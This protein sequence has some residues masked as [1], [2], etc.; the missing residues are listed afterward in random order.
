MSTP[1]SGKPYIIA[2]VGAN[3]NGSF[4]TAMGLID[5]AALAKA[6][7]VK[8][9]IIF[10]EGLYLPEFYEN[11]SYR[12][13]PVIEQRRKLML[14]DSE[15]Q[16]LAEHAKEKNIDFSASVFDERGLDLLLECSPKY[17]KL[18]SCDL[19]NPALLR[20]AAEKAG[21]KEISIILSTGFSTYEEIERSVNTIS[22]SGFKD[23]ILLHCVSVYPVRLAQ[24]NLGFIDQ[25]KK[26]GFPV[27]LSDHT[28]SN[29]AAAVALAKGARYFEKHVTLDKKQ[30][31]FDHAHSIEGPELE[32]Y[33][34]HINEAF[35]ALQPR[36]EKLTEDEKNVKKRARR[37]LYAARDIK[38]GEKIAEADIL[39]V[40]PEA[41][42]SADQVDSII[43][44]ICKNDM[45]KFEPF[46]REIV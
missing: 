18:A 4:E 8:F 25:L 33:V 27:G 31:G 43:G 6:D 41:A 2:E 44:K 45:K 39:I 37:A 26:F 23:L 15:Y 12:P 42:M 28:G 9:Q 13:N 29:T 40:R 22:K 16:K 24:M 14:K 17:I 36:A 38:A 35:E 5:M 46:T 19:N 3:H 1:G 32:K 20:K 7:S 10:P 21:R 11:G 34:A 30:E